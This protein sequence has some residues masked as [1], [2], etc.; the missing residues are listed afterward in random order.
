M[1]LSICILNFNT[2]ELLEA[3][4]RSIYTTTHDLD[5]EV[6]V[7][8]NASTDGSAAMTHQKFPQVNLIANVENRY[9]T[10]GNNQMFQAATGDYI[11]IMAGDVALENNVMRDL[12][13]Y[14]DSHPK[15][16]AA[17]PQIKVGT[18]CS[19]YSPW[20]F[21]ALDRT[22]LHVLLPGVYKRLQAHFLL[23]DWDR[24]VEREVEVASN[25][26]L[27]TAKPFWTRSAASMKGCYS[28]IPKKICAA[29]SG[30]GHS[31]RFAMCQFRL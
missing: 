25:S 19:R 21:S 20:Q 1:K 31:T 14:L 3:S 11:F 28:T 26:A 6:I 5:F 27:M 8:D 15:V 18:T 29:R 24:N 17:T 13:A 9:F 23:T 4:L 10:R 2:R 7:C 22:F 16:G 30:I 12:V